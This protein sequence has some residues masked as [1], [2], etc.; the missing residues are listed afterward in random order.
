MSMRTS[1][2]RLAA[3]PVEQLTGVLARPEAED[4]AVELVREVAR[5]S[6][7]PASFFYAPMIV[8]DA[9]TAQRC[10]RSRR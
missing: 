7:G 6:N 4:S 10:A 2:T 3:C 8:P 5:I 1:L 9:V